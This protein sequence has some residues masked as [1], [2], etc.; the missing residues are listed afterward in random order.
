MRF[1][2]LAS[3]SRGNACYIETDNTNILIDAGLS[4][5]E[6]VRRLDMINVRA[7][8]FDALVITHE[9]NDHIRGA[10]AVSRRFNTPLLLNSATFRQGT[11]VLGNISSPITLK[12][13]HSII[14][15][16]IVVDTF[17]KCHDAVDPMGLIISSNGAR[18]GIITDLGRST[19]L[20]ADRLRECNAVLIEFNHDSEMLDKGP[21]PLSLK[22]RIKGSEGHL[23][24]Q[25]AG[26]L[27]KAIAHKGIKIVILAHISEKNN[28]PEK[29]LEA[30]QTA[31]KEAGISE[32]PVYVSSQ[33][34]PGPLMEI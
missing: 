25:Q 9:H 20:V 24:N 4:C 26:E 14:I 11:R 29:A 19:Q 10:G 33:D 23:S 6:I 28:L 5:R 34:K 13:G 17:T 12:T 16:D 22:R 8:R 27:L 1:S 3:G 21:Y 31:L 2:V 15:N 18:L 7:E 32:V 30:A